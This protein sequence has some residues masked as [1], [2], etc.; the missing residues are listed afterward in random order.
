[1]TEFTIDV[2]ADV[3]AAASELKNYQRRQLPRIARL[4]VNKAIRGGRTDAKNLL[5]KRISMS[6]GDI[7]RRIK[8]VQSKAGSKV[9][10]ATLTIPRRRG[11][12]GEFPNLASFTLSKAGKSIRG[13]RRLPPSGLGAKVWGEKKFKKYRGVFVWDRGGAK[14]AFKR[15]RNAPKV[16]PSKRAGG[17]RSLRVFKRGPKK[18][19][20]IK[21]QP[22]APVYGA[23]LVREFVRRN[24]NS[25]REAPLDT[26]RKTVRTR[27]IKEFNRLLRRLD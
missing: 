22:I 23:S 6:V 25:P 19:R 21:R 7:A 16:V 8:I 17:D 27:F 13:K 4:S 10:R 5:K 26:V 15:V 14:T 20:P 24:R 1:M 2:R 18:G 9:I 12:G 3:A 11:R